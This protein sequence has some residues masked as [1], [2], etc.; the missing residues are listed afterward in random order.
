[1][2]RY[3]NFFKVGVAGAGNHDQRLFWHSWGE[4]YNGLPQDVNY[5]SQANVNYA[6]NLKGK[7]MLIHGLMDAGVHPSALFQ[8][9]QALINANKDFELVLLPQKGHMLSG[10]GMRQQFNFFYE[11]LSGKTPPANFHLKSYDDYLMEKYGAIMQKLN[12]P[13]KAYPSTITCEILTSLGNIELKLYPEKAPV[14]VAN[15]IHYIETAKYDS[16]S[17]FRVTTEENEKDKDIQISVVQGG[18]IPQ[19]D[20]FDAIELE[21]TRMTGLQ[22]KVGAISMARGGPNTATSSF[23][24]C[25]KDEPE[26][27]FGGARNADGQGF[28]TFG[29]VVKGIDV[30][31]KIQ[32][33]DNI[34]QM[35]VNP[36]IINTI[37]IINK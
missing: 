28:A 22:H 34:D 12:M 35:L 9:S 21:T 30:L 10:Y 2:L 36:I 29:E 5:L 26:L 23:F 7:L 32:E 18:Y 6:K 11:N 16:T 20:C 24:I 13:V 33:L 27:D 17:F 19:E 8:L 1:M 15:F 4:R 37:R 25:T 31:L 14:T 3:P